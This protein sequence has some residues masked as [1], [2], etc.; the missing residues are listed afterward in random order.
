MVTKASPPRRSTKVRETPTTYGAPPAVGRER[1]IPAGEFKARC[2][3]LMD[4][5]QRSGAEYV[6]TKRGVPV[7]RLLPANT[8]R[9][10]LFGSQRGSMTAQ[11]DIVS[12]LAG[13]WE[14][15]EGWHGED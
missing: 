11:G 3:A 13:A 4:E 6:I 12:P 10:P 15:L 9:R 5:V 2:L 7:A 14:A 1:R 8:E